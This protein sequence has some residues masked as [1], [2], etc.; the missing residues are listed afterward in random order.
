MFVKEKKLE[1][2]II[3][4]QNLNNI[5]FTDEIRFSIISVVLHKKNTT[6]KTSFIMNYDHKNENVGIPHLLCS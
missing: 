6:F 5:F 4:S 1:Q 2:N 3:L